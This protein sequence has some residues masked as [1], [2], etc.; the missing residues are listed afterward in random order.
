MTDLQPSAFNLHASTLSSQLAKVWIHIQH[1][2][3]YLS[4]GLMEAALFAP[5]SFALLPWARYWPPAQILLWLVLIMFLPFN[6]ARLMTGLQIP[7]SRQQSIMAIAL[8]S[9][10]IISIR[11]LIYAPQSLFDLSWLTDFFANI[12]QPGNQLWI[13]DVVIFFLIVIMWQRGLRL[14]SRSFEIEQAGFRLRLGILIAPLAIWFNY[15][16]IGWNTTPFILLFFLAG[17]MAI[18]LIRAEQLEQERSG[19]SAS[20]SPRWLTYIFAATLFTVSIAGSLAAMISGDS[21]YTAVGWMAPLINAIKAGGTV[22]IR[23]ILHIA[24]PIIALL[25]YIIDSLALW[26]ARI[27]ANNW[28]DP[29]IQP[30]LDFG[31]LAVTPGATD[32]VDVIAPP[33]LNSRILAILLMVAVVLIVS[34]F[35]GRLFRQATF[36]A[37]NS[38]LIGKQ[39]KQENDEELGLGQRILQ[40]LGLW[41]RWRAA[42]SVRRIYKQMLKAAEASGFPRSA[43]ETPYEYLTTLAQAWPENTTDSQL[44]TQAYVKVR[45]GELPE[46]PEE[47]EKL[48]AAWK[49]LKETRPSPI[50]SE[51]E[52]GPN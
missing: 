7:T 26:L 49:Q 31:E 25:A 39:G 35:L 18:A 5:L 36:A 3:L 16:G 2:L 43:A 33:N 45:Y 47:L 46:T 14:T 10:I 37:R 12:A 20:L 32:V 15:V 4:W 42:A 50:N 38:E 30:T 21:L 34:L 29:Q 28:I 8:L 22:I 9:T 23:T 51:S 52:V 24:Q 13:R 44:I 48:E 17:L 11:S 6:L 40:Q 41:R 27:A 19:F 1:E